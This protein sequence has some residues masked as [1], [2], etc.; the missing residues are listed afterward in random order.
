MK[1]ILIGTTLFY[2]MNLFSMEINTNNKI[3]EVSVFKDRAFVTRSMNRSVKK[4]NHSL[5]FYPVTNSLDIDSLKVTGGTESVRILGI[6]TKKIHFKEAVSDELVEYQKEFIALKNKISKLTII[7][8]SLL[9]EQAELQNLSNYYQ[10]SFSLNIQNGKWSPKNLRSFIKFLNSRNKKM[11]GSWQNA[12]KKYLKLTNRL[13]FVSNKKVE[14]SSNNNKVFLKVWIDTEIIKTHKVA[15]R[16]QYMVPNAGWGPLYDIRVNSKIARAKIFQSAK[17]WQ[18]TG[19]DWGNVNLV[20]SNQRSELRPKVPNISS[21]RLSYKEVKDVK[22]V[23]TSTQSDDQSLNKASIS[24]VAKENLAKRFVIK[25]KQTIKTHRPEVKVPIAQKNSTYKEWRELVA[26]QFP[27]V[28]KKGE[29]KN[30][31][32]Y[33]LAA[34]YVN[35]FY[36]D[37]FIS[38]YYK[39]FTQK[40]ESFYINSG[41]D[42]SVTV[43]RSYNNKAKTT[44]PLNGG[45]TYERKYTTSIFNYSINS[46]KVKVYEQIPESE[47]TDV[48]VLFEA[49]NKNFTKDEKRPSW[50]YWTLNLPGNK[51]T[52]HQHQIQIETPKDFN[53]SW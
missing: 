1:K 12:F 19:E 46:K 28:Y 37:N 51:L 32:N 33:A 16:L 17:V 40:G 31:F 34:G 43:N 8:S 26:S 29:I 47:L 27:K 49:N 22:T 25:A 15:L 5:V 18:K 48:K 30:P 11:T 2:S 38:K 14:L 10:E 24:E 45:R 39:D 41:I 3:S 9:K 23:V 50:V 21:Y 42:Y 44:G 4:G 7:V 20:L 13:E 53:F 36:D 35:I 52:S 6:R